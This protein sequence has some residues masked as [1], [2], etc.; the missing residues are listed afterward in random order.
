MAKLVD[1]IVEGSLKVTGTLT[2][3][4]INTETGYLNINAIDTIN[5]STINIDT[6]NIHNLHITNSAEADTFISNATNEAPFIVNSKI[7]VDNLNAE[8]LGGKKIDQFVTLNT[9]VNPPT[10]YASQLPKASTKEYG[11]IKIATD[12]E[13]L[14]GEATDKAITPKQLS[15]AINFGTI[16]TKQK[17]GMVTL[18]D[19]YTGISNKVSTEFALHNSLLKSNWNELLFGELTTYNFEII[20]N[21]VFN[22]QGDDVTNIFIPNIKIKF[23]NNTN[24]ITE[25]KSS[26]FSNNISNPYTKIIVK[27]N[28]KFPDSIKQVYLYYEYTKINNKSFA[29][30]CN[31]TDYFNTDKAIKINSDIYTYVTNSTYDSTNKKTIIN[32]LNEVIP[33][34]ISN[35][36]LS[37]IN[38]HK[39]LPVSYIRQENVTLNANSWTTVSPFTYTINLTGIYENSLIEIL[40]GLNITTNE[41]KAL[42]EANIV[43]GGQNNTSITLKSYGNKPYINIPIRVLIYGKTI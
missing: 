35:I 24:Y 15:F 4:Q 22:V 17:M 25:V 34:T 12:N 8:Y 3:E 39:E 32:V 38:N 41:L 1:S 27:D 11:A 28:N 29:I 9:S 26:E 33:N 2:V 19:S 5:S 36:Y 10:I 40:P 6:A 18:S 13:A 43:D 21:N 31:V 7:M 14:V 30:N 42:Q 20:N 16:A 23:N 37:K